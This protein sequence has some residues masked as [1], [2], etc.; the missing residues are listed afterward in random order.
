MFLRCRAELGPHQPRSLAPRAEAMRGQLESRNSGTAK[1][2]GMDFSLLSL[3]AAAWG[4]ALISQ[5]ADKTGCSPGAAEIKRFQTGAR[6]LCPS[7]RGTAVCSRV[8]VP[9]PG[10][11]LTLSWPL[12]IW[13]ALYPA[14]GASHLAAGASGNPS[15]TRGQD[16]LPGPGSSDPEDGLGLVP[17]CPPPYCLPAAPIKEQWLLICGRVC[18]SRWLWKLATG[19]QAPL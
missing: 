2:L 14:S 3:T 10:A 9:V 7:L 18:G 13:G 5:T 12:E 19:R 17:A 6:A 4:E 8:S 16:P 1:V 11:G 15:L